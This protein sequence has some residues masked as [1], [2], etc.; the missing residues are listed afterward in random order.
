LFKMK[1]IET[2]KICAKK[3][4]EISPICFVIMIPNI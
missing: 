1:R 3:T 4:R 2:K